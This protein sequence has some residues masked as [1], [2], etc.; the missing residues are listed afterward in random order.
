MAGIYNAT[1]QR[2]ADYAIDLEFLDSE[3]VPI[4]LTGWTVLAQVYSLGKVEVLGSFTVTYTSR[5][6]GQVSLQLA[7]AV[8][9][10]L[11]NEV[12]YDVKLI[13]TA[14]FHEYYLEGT[15]TVEV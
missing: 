6:L 15:L 8:V 11:P 10:A 12:I 14:N 3:K 13:D 1:L 9:D 2:D 7:R 5:P 4:D